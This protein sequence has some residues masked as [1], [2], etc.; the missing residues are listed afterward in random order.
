MRNG[1]GPN[2]HTHT[3]KQRQ[4]YTFCSPRMQHSIC[5]T[6]LYQLL[7]VVRDERYSTRSTRVCLLNTI[8]MVILGCSTDDVHVQKG[9][10]VS[11]S[12]RT[13]ERTNDV[14]DDDAYKS[15][16]IIIFCAHAFASDVHLTVVRT[17]ARAR[18]LARLQHAIWPRLACKCKLEFYDRLWDILTCVCVCVPSAST[19]AAGRPAAETDFMTYAAAV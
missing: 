8:Y 10:P 4:L 18:S 14:V 16:T 3:Q 2:T 1:G 15:P 9:Q 6:L 17:R 12:E 11:P 5:R 7:L 19:R 13:N